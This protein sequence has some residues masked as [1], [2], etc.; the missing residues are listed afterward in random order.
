MRRRAAAWTILIVVVVVTWMYLMGVALVILFRLP[1]DMGLPAVGRILGVPLILVGASLFAWLLRYR[2]FVDILVSTHASFVK[3]IRHAPL[4]ERLDR[5]E[6]LVVVGPYRLVRHPMYSGIGIMVIGI[7]IL[8]DH[9]WALL[10]AILLCLWFA[11]VVAPFE[12]RELTALFG[13]AYVDYMRVT[14][15]IIP[16]PWRK[17][18][19]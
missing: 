8:V 6:P 7:G 4:E 2:N 10:G 14:P 18:R 15:R 9:T 17:W 19:R 16:I 5:T 1:W 11:F 13:Q 3:M 12:E